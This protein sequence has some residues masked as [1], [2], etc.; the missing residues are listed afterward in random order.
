MVRHRPLGVALV[1]LG[2]IGV[3]GGVI[4]LAMN[5]LRIVM[6]RDLWNVPDLLAHGTEA[7]GLSV[8]WG[9]LSAAM[10]TCLGVFLLWAGVA[11]IKGLTEARPVTWC[12]VL[13]GILVNLTDMTI[14][15][16]HAKPGAMRNC[17][18]VLDGLALAIPVA[19]GIWLLADRGIEQPPPGDT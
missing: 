9:M 17:M 14:F 8:E 18:L 3:I 4:P 11:W 10:G 7:M 6:S 19:L 5:G 1:L 15:I 2:V 16:C 12:Y 13:S